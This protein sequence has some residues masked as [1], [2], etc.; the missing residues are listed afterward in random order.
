MYDQFNYSLNIAI[1]FY[2]LLKIEIYQSA[3]NILPIY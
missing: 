1:D 2:W 3:I